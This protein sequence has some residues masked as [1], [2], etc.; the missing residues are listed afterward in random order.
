MARKTTKKVPA[1]LAEYLSA[2]GKRGGKARLK[3]LTAEERSEIARKAAA[4]SAK[5]RSRKAAAKKAAA[6][7]ASGKKKA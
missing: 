6:N 5:V 2:I 7:K 3:K 4:A 1:E